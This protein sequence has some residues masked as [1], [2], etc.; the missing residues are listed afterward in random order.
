M[1]VRY[2]WKRLKRFF[3]YRVLHVDDTPHRIA[4]G[5]AI[6][7]FIT[8]SPTIP[9]QMI[10]TLTF[11]ALL[12]ANK[13]VGV[14]FVWISNPLTVVPIYYPNYWLGATLLGCRSIGWQELAALFRPDR[15]F[16][17][18]MQAW[19]TASGHILLPLWVGSVIVGLCVAVPSYFLTRWAVIRYRQYRHRHHPELYGEPPTSAETPAALGGETKTGE[20]T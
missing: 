11:S 8:W 18:W 15:G 3:I 19:W 5:V 9:C 20:P 17:E 13:F 7:M 14:P 1:P 2:V 6:G 10:L 16:S 12:R 4:L